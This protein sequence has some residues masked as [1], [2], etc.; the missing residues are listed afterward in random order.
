MNICIQMVLRDHLGLA[1]SPLSECINRLVRVKVH[2]V[3][4][5]ISVIKS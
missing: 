2:T 5:Y 4:K 1:W 3:S